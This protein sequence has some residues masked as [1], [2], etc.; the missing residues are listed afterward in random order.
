MSLNEI[1]VTAEQRARAI[2]IYENLN[3]G[4]ISLS[5]FDLIMARVAIVS[6]DNFYKRIVN[7]INIKR[8]YDENLLPSSIRK[9]YNQRFP[10]DSYNAAVNTSCYSNDNNKI[11]KCI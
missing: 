2:D 8:N 11:E 6:K 5:T 4:G 1:V 9:F 10:G 7:N 3:R